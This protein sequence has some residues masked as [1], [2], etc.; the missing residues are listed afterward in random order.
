M[1]SF[2]MC[3]MFMYKST[4]K[5]FETSDIIKII[6]VCSTDENILYKYII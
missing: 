6:N 2:K 4:R 1:K 3:S 5:N